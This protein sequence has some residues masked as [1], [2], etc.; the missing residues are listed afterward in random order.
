MHTIPRG[1][2]QNKCKLFLYS[3]SQ[4]SAHGLRG[5]MLAPSRAVMNQTLVTDFFILGCSETPGLRTLLFLAFLLLYT[6]ALSG[7]LLIVVVISSSPAL[8]TPTYF[9]LVNLA[10]V[11]ILCSPRS[12][13]SF[14]WAW[15]PARP[16]PMGLHGPALLLHVVHGGRAAAL[17]GHGL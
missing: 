9:F 10:V 11:D 16:S 3:L 6:V 12:Y 17:L 8:H 1:S 5:T 14:W 4:N 7:H 2:T 13:L 15:W